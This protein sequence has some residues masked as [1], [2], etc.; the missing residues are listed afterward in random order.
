PKTHPDYA[1]SYVYDALYRLKE[2]NRT[3]LAKH[4]IYGY[5]ELGNRTT[6]QVDNSVSTYAYNEKNQLLST[7]GGGLLRFRGT[8]NEPGT[9][10][11]NGQPARMRAGNSSSGYAN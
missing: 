5:D 2:V 11:V 8:L 3:G 6:E 7:T 1:E 10:T 9:V 4:W